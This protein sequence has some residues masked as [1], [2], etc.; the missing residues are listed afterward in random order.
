MRVEPWGPNR[1]GTQEGPEEGAA[2]AGSDA[3]IGKYR[4][5]PQTCTHCDSWWL[6]L[7]T[8]SILTRTASV[9]PQSACVHPRGHPEFLS[10]R[11][12]RCSV[13]G[14]EALRWGAPLLGPHTQPGPGA[15][16]FQ[17]GPVRWALPAALPAPTGNGSPGTA[18][19]RG[20]GRP[21][22]T[23]RWPWLPGVT[24][25]LRP[26]REER[27]RRPR[28]LQARDR[29]VLTPLSNRGLTLVPLN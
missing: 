17:E 8:R 27:Q 29:K 16:G 19:G 18:L 14:P 23:W 6:S 5:S 28:G 3:V 20:R 10:S 9:I 11:P 26:T 15:G 22:S 1:K 4:L 24:P 2:A 13:L 25:R 21:G 7:K 12:S